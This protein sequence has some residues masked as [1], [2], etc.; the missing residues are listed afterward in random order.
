VDDHQTWARRVASD[1]LNMQEAASSLEMWGGVECTVSRVRDD[2]IDQLELTGHAHRLSDI[3]RIA[4][5]G[6]TALRY[7]VIWERTAPSG[8]A[9]A[10][11]RWPDERLALIRA[12]G[13]NPIVGLVHHGSGPRDTSLEDPEFPT[14]LASYARACAERYPWLE[15]VTPLNEPLT[16][17]RFAGLYGHW[18]PHMTDDRA[19]VRMLLAECIAIR[20]AMRAIREIAPLAGLLQTE[21]LGHTHASDGLSYQA[22]FENE[23]RWLTWD[24]LCGHVVRGHPMYEYLV[25]HGA[26]P[27]QLDDIASNPCPPSLVGIDHYITS[28]RYL[29]A[30]VDAYEPR[31]RGG[32]RQNRY[33]DVEVTRAHP[34]IRR[35]AA[36]LL[37]DAWD[38]YRIPLVLAE[39]HL[40][41][42]DDR[43]SVRWLAELWNAALGARARG[44]D[45]RAV[46]A[47]ALFGA[48]GWDALATRGDGRY[49]AG[50]FDVAFDAA[51]NPP[52]EPRETYVARAIR[53]LARNG[54]FYEDAL[55][56][57]GWWQAGTPPALTEP[58]GTSSSS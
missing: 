57:P 29:D 23:R 24:L 44:C 49:S 6:V 18:Y 8:V 56:S 10:N 36:A 39:V 2:Y 43:E 27:R 16:T 28:E 3:D 1:R 45:V 15:L 4:S 48:S 5:L 38:R 21:D 42:D 34:E 9:D 11:W 31:Y 58:G 25:T 52:G 7:P 51:S 12:H 55:A 26:P 19:F 30:D 14:K 46:T 33:A 17:A 13:I 20:A 41:C 32:N 22:D 54:W 35:G 50:A 53:A 47:W 37:R 40:A